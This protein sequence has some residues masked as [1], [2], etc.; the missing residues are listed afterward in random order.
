[1]N[2]DDFS[3]ITPKAL[4]TNIVESV[5]FAGF[6]WIVAQEIDGKYQDEMVRTIILYNIAIIE[7][8]LLFRVKK[9][10]ISI[11]DFEFKNI[12]ILP[13]V[14][15]IDDNEIIVAK[16]LLKKKKLFWLYELIRE[17]ESFLGKKLSIEI[18]ELQDIRNTFH[19]SKERSE[20]S[21]KKAGSSFDAVLKVVKKLQK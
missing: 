4:Q 15:R 2:G 13:K 6:L 1:M 19:L 11:F 17:Q 3:F 8:L 12:H 16:K 10:N 18:K 20:L 7:A 9:E 5:E 21:L 14:Y